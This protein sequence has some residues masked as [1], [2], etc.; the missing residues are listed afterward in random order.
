MKKV[1][2]IPAKIEENIDNSVKNEVVNDSTNAPLSDAQKVAQEQAQALALIM[3]EVDS[4]DTS[5]YNP[6]AHLVKQ[7]EIKAV[8]DKI[9]LAS[10][11]HDEAST[12]MLDLHLFGK[13]LS[14]D[15]ERKKLARSYAKNPVFSKGSSDYDKLF[16]LIVATLPKEAQAS[17]IADDKLT[18]L[19]DDKVKNVVNFDDCMVY[20]FNPYNAKKERVGY[21]NPELSLFARI[22]AQLMLNKAQ[23][24]YNVGSSEQFHFVASSIDTY[25]KIH[26]FAKCDKTAFMLLVADKIV[27]KIERAVALKRINAL[28]VNEFYQIDFAVSMSASFVDKVI[29]ALSSDQH[30]APK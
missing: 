1:V 27:D 7:K 6:I 24:P 4:I 2:K 30:D 23:K 25:A 18:V 11:E 3:Q 9:K 13:V 14:S 20:L 26:G 22:Q 17:K 19:F 29:E 5:K 15:D 28:Q 16:S 8:Q 10:D 12:V 21:A